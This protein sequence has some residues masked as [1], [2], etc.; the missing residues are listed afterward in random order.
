MH[1]ARTG[2]DDVENGAVAYPEMEQPPIDVDTDIQDDGQ[3][4]C[5]MVPVPSA[6]VEMHII[7]EPGNDIEEVDDVGHSDAKGMTL[8]STIAHD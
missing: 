3:L 8:E 7:S 5:L 2:A 4:G 6:S 1:T